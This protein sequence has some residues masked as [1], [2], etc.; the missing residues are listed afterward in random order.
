MSVGMFMDALERRG[1]TFIL[2]DVLCV[3][4][5]LGAITDEQRQELVA[6]RGEVEHLVRLAL[7]PAQPAEE[8]VVAHDWQVQM[9]LGQVA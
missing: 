1:V 6:R 9:A 4:I 3:E 5:P 2:D 8:R 7:T